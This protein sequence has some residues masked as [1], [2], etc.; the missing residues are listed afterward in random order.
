MSDPNAAALRPFVDRGLRWTAVSQLAI[1]ATR[2]FVVLALARLLTPRE[3]GL[4]AMVLVFSAVAHL[5]TDLT[6]GSALVQRRELLE[7]HRSTAFW[8]SAGAGVVLALI[9]MAV[10]GPVA[11]F[12]G[13]PRVEALFRAVNLRSRDHLNTIITRDTTHLHE[14]VWAG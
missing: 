2:V 5:F 1:L 14:L 13:E 7:V 3:L 9:G 8:T 12:Y 10:A 11:D 4:A 6:L